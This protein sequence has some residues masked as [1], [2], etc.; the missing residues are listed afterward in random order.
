MV[1]G[2]D[3][4]TFLAQRMTV[5]NTLQTTEIEQSAMLVATGATGDENVPEFESYSPFDP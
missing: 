3:P 2:P 5:W 4:L 1:E